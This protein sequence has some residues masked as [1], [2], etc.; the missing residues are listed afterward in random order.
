MAGKEDRAFAKSL[1]SKGSGVARSN[2]ATCAN[3]GDCRQS[4]GRESW[5]RLLPEAALRQKEL[6][7]WMA[8]AFSDQE[9]KFEQL[10]LPFAMA[11]FAWNFKVAFEE[12]KELGCWTRSTSFCVLSHV[13]AVLSANMLCVVD[14]QVQTFVVVA[15]FRLL[16][17]SKARPSP[18]RR[19]CSSV[20]KHARDVPVFSKELVP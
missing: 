17:V 6:L 15:V 4:S 19:S 2:A 20:E 9:P 8:H 1:K 3:S 13:K 10:A 11:E 12:A 7:P 14:A 18:S 5:P 16:A